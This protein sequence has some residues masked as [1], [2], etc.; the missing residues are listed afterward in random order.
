MEAE[1]DMKDDAKDA[2]KKEG[3]LETSAGTAAKVF[4]SSCLWLFTFMICA[5]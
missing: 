4:D 3:N 5:N 2:L 1:A